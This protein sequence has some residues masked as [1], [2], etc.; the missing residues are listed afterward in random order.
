MAVSIRKK[1][2]DAV[3]G[4]V[5]TS[6]LS[7]KEVNQK[8]EFYERGYYVLESKFGK[9]YDG[10]CQF[11]KDYFGKTPKEDVLTKSKIGILMDS[12]SGAV[13][14]ATDGLINASPILDADIN[15]FTSDTDVAKYINQGFQI[16]PALVQ[17]LIAED[18][19][20]FVPMDRRTAIVFVM[21]FYYGTTK[22]K[23]KG[24]DKFQSNAD[25]ALH[26]K[27]GS[28]AYS[29]GGGYNR[30]YYSSEDVVNGFIGVGDG[31]TTNF[32]SA[33][34]TYYLSPLP[35]VFSSI[36]IMT[37]DTNGVKTTVLGGYN[38]NAVNIEDITLNMFSVK[39]GIDDFSIDSNGLITN[40]EFH[41]APASGTKILINHSNDFTNS[42]ETI[43][44]FK[45]AL[46]EI[47]LKAKK[48]QLRSSWLVSSAFDFKKG[49]GRSLENDLLAG[50]IGFVRHEIDGRILTNLKLG[51]GTSLPAFDILKGGST[52]NVA[53]IKEIGAMYSSAMLNAFEICSNVIFEKTQRVKGNRVMVG[54]A[55]ASILSS[56]PENYGW[57]SAPSDVDEGVIGSH[58]LGTLNNK[59]KVYLT[60][61][62]APEEFV[63]CHKPKNDLFVSYLVGWYLPLFVTPRIYLADTTVQSGL[64][65]MYAE[66]SVNELM[67]VRS[68]IKNYSYGTSVF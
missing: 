2:E 11:L 43:P 40:L 67:V 61:W 26:Y 63:V 1:I 14:D 48:Y 57:K 9:I 68:S 20:T 29:S 25:P 54:T 24:W 64:I 15:T 44:Y 13:R 28:G 66:K 21:N 46:D 18:I 22:G 50:S 47:D 27:T 59:W 23:I 32:G 36:Q 33:Y 60:P 51:A 6:Q 53:G 52:A 35:V 30:A 34:G 17:L 12:Y 10:A 5:E 62:L 3:I 37:E 38:G 31:T 7:K 4:D 49:H 56:I 41:T 45:I 19:V 55:V 65:S 42:P 39:N 8:V 58:F 16:I